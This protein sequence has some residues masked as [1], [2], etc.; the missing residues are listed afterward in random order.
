MKN[1][2]LCIYLF[3]MNIIENVKPYIIRANSFI[4]NI[5]GIISRTY[6]Q[7]NINTTDTVPTKIIAGYME[8]EPKLAALKKHS[9]TLTYDDLISEIANRCDTIRKKSR[10]FTANM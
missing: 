8:H 4:R 6:S 10:H 5:S 9:K 3:Y 2:Y 1:I 7:R